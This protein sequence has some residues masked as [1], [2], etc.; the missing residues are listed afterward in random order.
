MI[1]HIYCL[2]QTLFPSFFASHKISLKLSAFDYEFPWHA[3]VSKTHAR[4]SQL[5]LVTG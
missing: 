2:M 5:A 4:Q 1:K 3:Q